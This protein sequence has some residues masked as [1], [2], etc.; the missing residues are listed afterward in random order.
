MPPSWQTGEEA[1]TTEGAGN[2]TLLA[3]R[4]YGLLPAALPYIASALRISLHIAFVVI[5]LL[6]IIGDNTGLGF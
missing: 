2:E 3:R 1:Q 4:P 5:V 6:E